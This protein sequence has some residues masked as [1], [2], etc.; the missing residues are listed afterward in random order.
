MVNKAR[1][2][3]LEGIE[4]LA[5]DSEAGAKQELWSQHVAPDPASRP[6][7]R[8]TEL[9]NDAKVED[10]NPPILDDA[11]LKGF[12]LRESSD[13]ELIKTWHDIVLP[14]LDGLLS[15]MSD[16]SIVVTLQR[17][18]LD[19]VDSQVTIRVCSS[20][21]RPEFEKV[22]LKSNLLSLLPEGLRSSCRVEFTRGSIRRS[23]IASKAPKTS[24]YNPP[25][26]V[27]RNRQW[28]PKP[29]MG[30][31]IG[32]GGSQ[33]HTA[34][35][36]GYLLIDGVTHILT[37]HHVFEDETDSAYN[38][39]RLRKGQYQITQPSAQ[40]LR[41]INAERLSLRDR[42]GRFEAEQA[43]LL[44]WMSQLKEL[45]RLQNMIPSD[46][47]LWHFG[48]VIAS[49]G[50]RNRLPRK[51]PDAQSSFGLRVRLPIE[52]D[53][54]ICS[55]DERRIGTNEIGN[56]EQSAQTSA[57]GSASPRERMWQ[58]TATHDNRCTKTCQPA[59][60]VA[61]HSLGRTSH[62]QTGVVSPCGTYTR[63]S[64]SSGGFRSAVEW[65]IMRQA[66]KSLADWSEGGMGVDGDSGSWIV[67]EDNNDLIGL[68][69]G[70]LQNEDI[71]DPVTLFTP[72]QDVFDDIIDTIGPKSLCLPQGTQLF[73]SET[74][75]G[76]SVVGPADKRKRDGDML[77][78]SK[79]RNA[80][81]L[82]HPHRC[83]KCVPPPSSQ[84]QV[85]PPGTPTQPPPGCGKPP[86]SCDCALEMS[87]PATPAQSTEW[88]ERGVRKEL[89]PSHR[90]V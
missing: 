56:P 21:S 9:G 52:M 39:G 61:V 1:L 66:S 79:R 62:Y 26:C 80:G 69:W 8:T 77:P 50:Y 4:R 3:L 38:N 31:S 63:Q 49:S 13:G 68:L 75:P 85:T 48:E 33:N 72:I 10:A 70:R 55:V 73:T 23:G 87:P 65:T 81:T 36:G 12:V 54:A 44:E 46:E 17:E 47:R 24:M 84:A 86:H 51:A 88:D 22:R 11:N 57:S 43:T 83:G 15:S 41:D 6:G 45:E 71:R 2:L 59:G 19:E 90:Y 74:L 20:V 82:G 16:P 34:T 5:S 32:R 27:P 25:I 30:A 35:L 89:S 14:A 18:G 29:V 64:T 7:G 58:T 60:G 37:V 67:R 40:E 78:P 76:V 28:L 42:I 53:W